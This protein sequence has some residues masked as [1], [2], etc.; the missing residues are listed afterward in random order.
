MESHRLGEQ[1]VIQ[2]QIA[3]FTENL[4]LR[5][6]IINAL[7]GPPG[8]FKGLARSGVVALGEPSPPLSPE[9]VHLSRQGSSR[10]WG[11]R[12][13][14]GGAAG[15][16]GTG[17]TSRQQTVMKTSRFTGLKMGRLGGS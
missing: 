3:Q 10:E 13:R 2:G 8:L 17:Q 16:H 7:S 11:R 4:H 9:S 15:A 6:Q 14:F 5:R 12:R 1:A